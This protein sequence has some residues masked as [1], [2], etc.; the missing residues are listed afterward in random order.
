[1]TCWDIVDRM[2]TQRRRLPRGRSALPVE[3]VE[4]VQR[5]RLCAAMAEVMAEKGY[6]ATSIEDVLRHAGVS[7]QTFYRYFTSKSDC[8]AA[9]FQVAGERVLGRVMAEVASDT[10]GTVLDRFERLIDA[11]I[12]T[13]LD[14]WP[15]ARMC[16]V[17]LFAAGPAELRNREARHVDIS[18]ILTDLIGAKGERSRLA[19]RMVFAAS[20][21]LLTPAVA[22]NDRE[23][24]KAVG[25]LLI[26]HVRN[27]WDAG[28]F[29]AR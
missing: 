13:L 11:Y 27:L 28:L 22:A 20:T 1:L 21:T 23:A 12:N 18:E 7:R 25:P 2:S 10:G 17:E 9:A 19:F 26:E 5:A 8:F 6:V 16:M 3:E 14:E 15:A 4:R 24:A 29:D